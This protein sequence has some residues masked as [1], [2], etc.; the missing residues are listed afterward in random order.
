MGKNLVQQARGKGGPR[1]R[2]PGFNFRGQAKHLSLG[3]EQR[4]GILADLVDCP[5]H[6]A[7]LAI[8]KYGTVENLTIAPEGIR[9]GERISAGPGSEPKRGNTLALRDIPDGTLIYNI[10][11]QPGDGGKF[12]RASG[13][14]ARVIGEVG[15]RIMV[16]LPSKKQKP[17]QP[18][19]RASIGTV[20]GS[21]RVEKPFLKAGAKFYAMKAKNKL[22]PI[23]SARS[24]N[25]VDHP[26][27]N[28]RSARKAKQRPAPRN[29][30]PGRNVGKLHPKRTGRKKK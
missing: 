18:D 24:Q 30:P 19:C 4:Q 2:S 23:T 12:C 25:A 28:K 8:I 29:A 6:S 10:E 5:G 26:F 1:Y 27:G 20:A 13:T 9:V 3:N 17:F 11:S 7:P 16:E 15:G 14:A 22:Y 21:G